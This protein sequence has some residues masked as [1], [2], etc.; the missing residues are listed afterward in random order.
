MWHYHFPLHIC[1]PRAV[2]QLL[3]C[4]QPLQPHELQPTRLL[5]PWYSSGKN[6][7][8]SYHF[9]LQGIFLTQGLNP[10]LLHCRQILYHLSHQGSP[11]PS[12]RSPELNSSTI[13]YQ[14]PFTKCFKISYLY[15][16]VQTSVPSSNLKSTFQTLN[17][18]TILKSSYFTHN[19]EILSLAPLLPPR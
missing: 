11:I 14:V 2:V 3:S 9:L 8:V 16:Q 15:P 13:L 4:V 10:R 7:E 1:L 12:Y 18:V 19:I 6:T 17:S 5:C